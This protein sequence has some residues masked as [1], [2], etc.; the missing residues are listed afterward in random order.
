ME[1][2]WFYDRLSQSFKMSPSHNFLPSEFNILQTAPAQSLISKKR[3][4]TNVA[5]MTDWV[6]LYI[7]HRWGATFTVVA[8]ACVCLL[9]K[10]ILRSEPVVK[11]VIDKCELNRF[12]DLALSETLLL[13]LSSS[14]HLLK[15]P[16]ALPCSNV[17][18][19]TCVWCVLWGLGAC[20]SWVWLK[21]AFVIS[22]FSCLW[23]WLTSASANNSGCS[24]SWI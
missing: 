2:S 6:L 13:V 24:C 4:S 10:N 22:C 18:A 1:T 21:S 5:Q 15:I 23:F 20:C 19:D 8:K 7:C 9:V 17:A 12:T 14:F 11:F 16:D 3:S